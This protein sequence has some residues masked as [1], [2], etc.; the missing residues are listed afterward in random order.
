MLAFAPLRD[1]VGAAGTALSWLTDLLE[2][3]A[4][5][6]ATAAAPTP[7]GTA[8]AGSGQKQLTVLIISGDVDVHGCPFRAWRVP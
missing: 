2:P 3:L 8:V 6:M 5:Q 1:V 4:G 7:G